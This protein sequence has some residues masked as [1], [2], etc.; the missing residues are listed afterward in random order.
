M[1]SQEI[2]RWFE[3][4]LASCVQLF[5]VRW[6]FCYILKSAKWARICH[7]FAILRSSLALLERESKQTMIPAMH[8]SSN[9]D[10]NEFNWWHTKIQAHTVVGESMQWCHTTQRAQNNERESI[11]VLLIA[12]T[13]RMATEV[14]CFNSMRTVPLA[15]FL[16]WALSHWHL[17]LN[18]HCLTGTFPYVTHTHACTHA[19]HANTHTA[20]NQWN[21]PKPPPELGAVTICYQ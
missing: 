7:S 21:F 4:T 10:L 14:G 15:P 16:M 18:Q 9:S 19:A 20:P 11:C 1:V 8:K 6:H 12:N 17:C 13:K 3:E 2:L 5:W